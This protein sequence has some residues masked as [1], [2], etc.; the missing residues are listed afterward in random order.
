M[1][2]GQ[3]IE[4]SVE[5]VC[6]NLVDKYFKCVLEGFLEEG[7]TRELFVH[8]RPVLDVQREQLAHKRRVGAVADSAACGLK[9]VRKSSFSL[10]F[11]NKAKHQ[12]YSNFQNLE[13][14]VPFVF[15]SLSLTI[16][17]PISWMCSLT[18]L[19]MGG[20]PSSRRR[21]NWNMR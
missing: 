1:A 8:E 5:S 14:F 15:A 11:S 6:K 19:A 4:V 18:I 17:N 10:K 13:S 3:L 16:A 9:T 20:K 7:V 2:Y 12:K 21:N